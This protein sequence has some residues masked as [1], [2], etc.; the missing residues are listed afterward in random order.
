MKMI[1]P[2]LIRNIL[3][4]CISTFIT[5]SCTYFEDEEDV[6]TPTEESTVEETSEMGDALVI[7]GAS[8]RITHLLALTEQLDNT[9]KL[10]NLN[11]I[12]GVSAGAIT[13]IALNGIKDDNDFDWDSYKDILLNLSNDDIFVNTENALPVDTSPLES[14]FSLFTETELGYTEFSDLSYNTVMTSV[15]E[16]LEEIK[17]SS[18]LTDIDNIGGNIVESL[19]SSTA[20]PYVFPSYEIDG[21]SYVDGG[22]LESIPISSV[23]EYES[24]V[25]DEFDNIYIV[26]KQHNDSVDLSLELDLLGLTDDGKEFYLSFINLLLESSGLENLLLKESFINSLYE[27]Q[28][29]YPDV[30]SRC[31]VYIPDVEDLDYYPIFDFSSET[32]QD[33]Y[34]TINNWALE[35]EPI[36]LADYLTQYEAEISSDDDATSQ[37]LN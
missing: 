6:E 12:S 30:A 35:N 11:F 25:D 4:I 22:L 27:I 33:S 20:Y 8:A 2:P 14:F 28:D 7:T 19:M 13:A 5:T 32:A 37:T 34:T 21:T 17:Y 10:D 3:L 15:D 24:L 23:I 9:G 31:Y 36:L 29:N 16:A 1:V 18:N 26:S